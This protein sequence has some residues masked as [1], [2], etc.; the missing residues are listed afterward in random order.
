MDKVQI[1]CEKDQM[2]KQMEVDS[3]SKD[4]LFDFLKLKYYPSDVRH[5]NIASL[6]RHKRRINFVL[7]PIE[8]QEQDCQQQTMAYP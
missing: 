2:F 5:E 1:F 4:D 8:F 3:E 6:W 7:E